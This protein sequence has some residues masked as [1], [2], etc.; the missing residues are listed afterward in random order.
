MPTIM[1]L[2][3]VP[4][5]QHIGLSSLSDYAEGDFGA[6]TASLQHNL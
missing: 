5:L 2:S 4:Q 6:L 3:G 1:C